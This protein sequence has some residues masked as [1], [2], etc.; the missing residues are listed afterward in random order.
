LKRGKDGKCRAKKQ[1]EIP[2]QKGPK[3]DR[4]KKTSKG[5]GKGSGQVGERESTNHPH[6][7]PGG[8]KSP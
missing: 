1:P 4:I 7:S 3:I 6:A 8:K 2:L 5:K